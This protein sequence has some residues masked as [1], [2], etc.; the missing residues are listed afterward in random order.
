MSAT[1]RGATRQPDDFYETPAWC[2]RRLLEVC[3][4]PSGLWYEPACGA[5][6]IFKAVN[7]LRP[8]L[9]WLLSDINPQLAQ[10]RKADFL[11]HEMLCP[12]VLITN[13]PYSLAFEFA[14]K[15]V[16]EAV[17]TVLLLRL[18]WLASAKRAGWLREH[19]PDVYVLPNRP[20]FING[21]TDSCEY[22]WMHWSSNTSGKLTILNTTP[23]EER[24]GAGI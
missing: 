17:H 6:A 15:A 14:K 7:A 5:G 2:V 10:A 4:L 24:N 8:E 19:T 13:P 9:H 1:S 20:S 12:D 22:A 18:N 3:S 16:R 21:K 23:K 11:T